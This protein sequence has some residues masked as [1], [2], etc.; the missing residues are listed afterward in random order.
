MRQQRNWT[1]IWAGC[2]SLLPRARQ[3]HQTQMFFTLASATE[4][5]HRPEVLHVP[6]I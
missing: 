3:C 4:L 1:G 2:L 6:D 5:K